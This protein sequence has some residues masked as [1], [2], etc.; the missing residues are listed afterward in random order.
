MTHTYAHGR[1]GRKRRHA[2]LD[3]IEN[4]DAV[5]VT[6][7]SN[8][9]G[10]A[11]THSTQF[12]RISDDNPHHS[13]GPDDRGYEAMGDTAFHDTGDSCGDRYETSVCLLVE[14]LLFL[15]TEHF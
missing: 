9:S 1:R 8:N 12:L 2:L 3:D 7:F 11:A 5:E 10:E 4:R 6:F 13:T 14:A 15:F